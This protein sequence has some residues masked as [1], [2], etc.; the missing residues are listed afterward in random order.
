[1]KKVYLET[2]IISFLTGKPSSNLLSAAWQNITNEWWENR[3]AVFDLYSSELVIEEAG[4][5]DLSASKKRLAILKGIPLLEVNDAVSHLSMKLITPGALPK[6][7]INDALH[8]S[9]ATI[10]K[11]DYLL[12]WNC[13]HIDNA[14][15]KPKMRGLLM[16]YGYVCPEICTPQELL[17][18]GRS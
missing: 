11:M 10:H 6:K 15:I 8:I 7:A 13:R 1:M 3:R 18:G 14:E 17:G 9:I 4:Q 2:S 12:T 5:G 16:K